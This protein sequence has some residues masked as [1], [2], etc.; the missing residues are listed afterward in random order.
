MFA[1][2]IGNGLKWLLR[3]GVSKERDPNS[4]KIRCLKFP[5]KLLG[6]DGSFTP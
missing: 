4:D 3:Q 5:I 6:S 2:K 1:R